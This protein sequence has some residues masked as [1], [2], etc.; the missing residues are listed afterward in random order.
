MTTP[1]PRLALVTAAIHLR[2]HPQH[3]HHCRCE[4]FAQ[5]AIDALTTTPTDP[6]RD[7][8]ESNE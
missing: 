3:P 6:P 5:A 8:E 1:D 2:R 4:E 7:L